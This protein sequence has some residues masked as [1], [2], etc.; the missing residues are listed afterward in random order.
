MKDQKSML[1]WTYSAV[2]RQR[3]RVG[4]EAVRGTGSSGGADG[5]FLRDSRQTLGEKTALFRRRDW[6]GRPKNSSSEVREE[7]IEGGALE[8]KGQK[9]RWKKLSVKGQS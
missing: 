6:H 5:S 4:N 2:R 1:S 7:P 3:E 9:S 8:S